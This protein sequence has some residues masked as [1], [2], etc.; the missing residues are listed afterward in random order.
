MNSSWLLLPLLSATVVVGYWSYVKVSLYLRRR[1]FSKKHGCEQLRRAP[2]KDPFLGLDHFFR[3]AKAAR[4]RQYL[5]HFGELFN[6]VGPTFGINLMGDNLVFTNEPKNV[7]AILVTKFRDF[8]IGQ[9]RRNNSAELL[10]V[11]V[12]NADGQIW[13]HGRALVR[14]NFTRKQVADLQLFEK[15]VRVLMEAIPTDG[16]P[17]DIQAWV[18]R[19][20][21]RR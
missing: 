1:R 11:G 12:F 19:F 21:S 8:E 14:P 15:H 16:T 9:R 17:F 10:G 13:E 4:K 7:Q 6:E 18:F 2:Q 3:L 5:R 20:V